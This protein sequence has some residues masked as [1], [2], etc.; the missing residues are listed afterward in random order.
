MREE[1]RNVCMEEKVYKQKPEMKL[2]KFGR[3]FKKL[4]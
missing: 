1:N 4:Q 3:K 2:E